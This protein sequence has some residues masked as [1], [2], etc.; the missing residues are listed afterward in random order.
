MDKPRKWKG[1]SAAAAAKYSVGAAS[2][3]AR[4]SAIKP[5]HVNKSVCVVM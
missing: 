1:S 3:G 2:H 5:A 4:G